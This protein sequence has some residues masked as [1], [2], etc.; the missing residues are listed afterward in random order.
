VTRKALAAGK[1]KNKKAKKKAAGSSS[2]FLTG[3]ISP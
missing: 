3:I 2:G 1:T